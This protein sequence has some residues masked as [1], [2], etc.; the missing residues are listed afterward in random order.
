MDDKDDFKS[1]VKD[2]IKKFTLIKDYNELIALG[3]ISYKRTQVVGDT[4]GDVIIFTDGNVWYKIPW[5][6]AT[7]TKMA[8]RSAQKN[9]EID[10]KKFISE[11]IQ[12]FKPIINAYDL[13]KGGQI[14]FEDVQVA[15]EGN[16]NMIVFMH[17]NNWCKTSYEPVLFES[18]KAIN[19]YRKKEME[20]DYFIKNN[21]R[22]FV[23]LQDIIEIIQLG[24]I[25]Y[26]ELRIS[27][28]GEREMLIFTDGNSWYKMPF[29]RRNHYNLIE[30][31]SSENEKKKQANEFVKSNV[32]MIPLITTQAQLN[33]VGI[34]IFYS[35]LQ[36]ASDGV[37]E[38][39]V[40]SFKDNF[41]K[42][43][44]NRNQK[45]D[46]F[47]IFQQNN[48]NLLQRLPSP[49]RNYDQHSEAR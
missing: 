37:S 27:K 48:Q 20:L 14:T 34:N 39:I 46:I 22:G 35:N 17:N 43:N 6:R 29:D 10:T 45:P 18:M 9:Y 44:Y 32:K 26:Q 3:D 15:K 13:V 33:A 24:E 42:L 25:F 41:Y 38:F 19:D 31:L 21:I 8:L 16:Q 11:N 28:E 1:W 12:S 47:E 2:N 36:I 40:F 30:Y 5:D 7:Y 23:F 49:T 4:L